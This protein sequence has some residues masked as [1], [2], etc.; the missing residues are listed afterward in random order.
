M[1]APRRSSHVFLP[2]VL[3]FALPGSPVA[4]QP[5]RTSVLALPEATAVA[6]DSAGA[7][8]ADSTRRHRPA[9]GARH[10]WP[11]P[12]QAPGAAAYRRQPSIVA[13]IVVG[14][15][16]A[17]LGAIG[18]VVIGAGLDE[19][20]SEDFIPSSAVVGFL[21]GEALVLPLGVHMGNA[22]RGNFLADL[23]ASIV[24]GV[25]AIAVGAA[26]NDGGAYLVG[27]GGQLA[28]TVW[29]ER[30]VAAHKARAQAAP[31]DTTR[32][33]TSMPLPPPEPE[34]LLPPPVPTK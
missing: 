11:R 4:A 22:G 12:D 14:T 13:P 8:R 23:G 29:T 30:R 32:H 16:G 6:A 18:G 3:A 15:L 17:G 28:M 25:C 10:E 5:W 19:N 9:V 34:P 21:A 2:A 27:L 26:F 24:G 31:A 33:M 1:S 7:A 20:G